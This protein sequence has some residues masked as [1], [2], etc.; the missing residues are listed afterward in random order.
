MI[1]ETKVP[2][3]AVDEDVQREIARVAHFGIDVTFEA[4]ANRQDSA[5]Q[6][7]RVVAHLIGYD[8]SER[9]FVRLSPT[10]M[11]GEQLEAL[12]RIWE[13]VTHPDSHR[14][15]SDY[16]PREHGVYLFAVAGGDVESFISG[17]AERIEEFIKVELGRIRTTMVS[18]ASAHY[19][20]AWLH[21]E[22][23]VGTF[24]FLDEYAEIIAAN[25]RAE[26]ARQEFSATD[27]AEVLNLTTNTVRKRLKGTSRFRGAEI[28]SV[29]RW[30]GVGVSDLAAMPYEDGARPTLDGEV[31]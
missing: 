16:Q 22:R 9:W 2:W 6:S 8:N 23:T 4:L 26:M 29:A 11:A 5:D 31:S 12:S 30:L 18:A 17:M 1:A 24:A 25:V 14:W 21:D 7:R 27:L 3:M 15:F 19:P 13:A 28:E 10:A 20:A